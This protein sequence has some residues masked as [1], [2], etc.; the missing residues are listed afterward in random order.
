MTSH[1]AHCSYDIMGTDQYIAPEAYQGDY[2]AS[3]QSKSSVHGRLLHI[4]VRRLCAGHDDIQDD[5]WA[6]SFP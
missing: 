5:N 2:T 3:M 6:L 1:H 4:G